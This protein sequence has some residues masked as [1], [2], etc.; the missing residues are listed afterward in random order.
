M[1][2]SVRYAALHP[3][4]PRPTAAS[5]R[6]QT[7]IPPART[8]GYFQAV[9]GVQADFAPKT[10]TLDNCR[11][12]RSRVAYLRPIFASADPADWAKAGD[13]VNPM[14]AVNRNKQIALR[15]IFPPFGWTADITFFAL[16]RSAVSMSFIP[17]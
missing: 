17:G 12:E 8:P 7:L 5:G 4:R 6:R 9:T 10:S 15:T 16:Q 2:A 14:N 13:K 3:A 11:V 1:S